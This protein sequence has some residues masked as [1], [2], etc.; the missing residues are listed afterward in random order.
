[1]GSS[2]NPLDAYRKDATFN[3]DE[4]LSYYQDVKCLEIRNNI[5]KTLEKDPLFRI[6]EKELTGQLPVTE[7]RH[8]TH[9]RMKKFLDYKFTTPEM[10]LEYPLLSAYAAIE[11]GMLGYGWG[12]NAR[13]ALNRSVR[14]VIYYNI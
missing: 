13:L 5:L 4:M 2:S 14:N 6:S 8:L 10:M 12:L 1:M 3:V 7:I 9:L 11:L